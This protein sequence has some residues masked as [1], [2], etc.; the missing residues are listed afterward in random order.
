MNIGINLGEVKLRELMEQFDGSRIKQQWHNLLTNYY[1]GKAT[2]R[3]CEIFRVWKFRSLH[4]WLYYYSMSFTDIHMKW[5][6]RKVLYTLVPSLRKR[7]K[8]PTK[9][10][11]IDDQPSAKMD[12]WRTCSNQMEHEASNTNNFP[13]QDG[14][15]CKIKLEDLA[16]LSMKVC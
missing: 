14:F 5:T 15:T 3:K 12:L 13:Q 11:S 8:L 4:I 16:N 6:S 10:S 9:I 1:R 7:K 2:W